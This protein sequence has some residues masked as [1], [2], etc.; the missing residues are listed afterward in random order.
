MLPLP[1]HMA[2]DHAVDHYT[3]LLTAPTAAEQ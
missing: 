3:V 2:E 1:M